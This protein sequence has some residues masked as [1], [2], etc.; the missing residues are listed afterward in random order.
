VLAASGGVDLPSYGHLQIDRFAVL[1]DLWTNEA[2]YLENKRQLLDCY[3][4]AYQ[5]V[6]DMHEKRALAQTI[7]DIIYKRP[8][9]DF[10]SKYFV[11]NYKMESIVLRLNCKLVKSILDKQI[12]DQRE[13]IQRVCRDGDRDFGLPHRI[14]PKQPVA[15]NLSRPA[16]SHVYLLE[17]HP[18]LAIASRL[19]T[20]IKFAYNELTNAHLPKTVTEQ[21]YMEKRLLEIAN[22]EWV[23]L[24]PMG[25]SFTSQIQRD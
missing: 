9:L 24:K 18:S 12:Q 3:L 22:K 19:P 11:S 15:I 17:F 4:E 1:L 25:S 14:I 7:T 6:F 5:H 21:I 10:A 23:K 13:Y 2:E 20:A 8:R 16:L